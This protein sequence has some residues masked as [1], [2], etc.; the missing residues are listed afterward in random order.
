M[1]IAAP[2]I[3]QNKAINKEIRTMS[4]EVTQDKKQII[5]EIKKLF[6][7]VNPK[8]EADFFKP[9]TSVLSNTNQVKP[10]TR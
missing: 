10:K 8:K 1:Y 6:L 9:A 2:A 3:R 7:E 4:V 5:K